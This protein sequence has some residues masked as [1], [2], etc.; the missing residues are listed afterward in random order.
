MALA[1]T[2]DSSL[3]LFCLMYIYLY[4]GS[5]SSPLELMDTVT[6]QIMK[7][8]V[9]FSL[10][11]QRIETTLKTL[12]TFP[13]S[14]LYALA[15]SLASE[16]ISQDSQPSLN[17]GG[18]DIRGLAYSPPDSP[19]D[20][21]HGRTSPRYLRRATRHRHQLP[22]SQMCHAQPPTQSTDS[23][24]GAMQAPRTFHSQPNLEIS[25]RTF[26]YPG[27]ADYGSEHFRYSSDY[28]QTYQSD[29][30]VY[31]TSRA[32]GYDT[33]LPGPGSMFSMPNYE[34]RLDNTSSR[35]PTHGYD[36]PRY[37]VLSP[38]DSTQTRERQ[39]KRQ[40]V[41]HGNEGCP[42]FFLD[43]DPTLFLKILAYHDV[44]ASDGE[45]VYDEEV[46]REAKY[47][48]IYYPG[49]SEGQLYLCLM[50][51]ELA[52]NE[53]PAKY[54]TELVELSSY[55]QLPRRWR[56]LAEPGDFDLL[57]SLTQAMDIASSE[58]K[59]RFVG[60]AGRTFTEGKHLRGAI[61]IEASDRESPDS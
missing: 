31:P 33:P 44:V 14:K 37:D 50:T 42:A 36:S 45:V 2:K 6:E 51:V 12:S 49:E 26:N 32:A 18:I 13:D 29:R 17:C 16:D 28:H 5:P 9:C 7:D 58:G 41:N 53:T 24:N 40:R 48:N 22:Q 54:T 1:D 21:S 61:I 11:G 39:L 56:E 30:P 35:R 20:R 55:V 19:R 8:R 10:R 38:R 23:Q 25:P 4:S 46:G 52:E 15:K 47:W 3:V 57:K 34:S 59:W 27:A 60:M 43:R